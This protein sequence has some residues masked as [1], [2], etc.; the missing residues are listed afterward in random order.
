MARPRKH[1]TTL[2]EMALVGFTAAREK[3]I[4]E[5]ANIER[6]LGRTGKRIKQAVEGVVPGRKKRT[7][8]ARAR[9]AISR[10]QKRRWSEARKAVRTVQATATATVVKTAKRKVKRTVKRVKAA[11]AG[12]VPF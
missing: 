11:T 10:A 4:E 7:L 2:L 9:A 1:D 3:I 8:S 6:Q 5:I 12:V